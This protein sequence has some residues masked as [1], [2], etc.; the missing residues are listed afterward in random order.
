MNCR[1]LVEIQKE[2]NSKNQNARRIVNTAFDWFF[3]LLHHTMSRQKLNPNKSVPQ[4]ILRP[5]VFWKKKRLAILFGQSIFFSANQLI[6]SVVLIQC[7]IENLFYP[8]IIRHHWMVCNSLV[9]TEQTAPYSLSSI[10]CMAA[11]KLAGKVWWTSAHC[12]LGSV[13]E[14]KPAVGILVD[15]PSSANA[16]NTSK[17]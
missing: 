8:N 2:G 17:S 10:Q 1:T 12:K 3:I 9:D 4:K 11:R 6:E 14:V 13:G 16:L 15:K 5:G 7:R